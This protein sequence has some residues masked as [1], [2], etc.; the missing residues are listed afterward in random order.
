VTANGLRPLSPLRPAVSAIQA[1]PSSSA[2]TCTPAPCRHAVITIGAER[3]PPTDEQQPKQT[4][5]VGAPVLD[6]S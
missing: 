1:A 4:P 5:V 2:A 6:V 3:T